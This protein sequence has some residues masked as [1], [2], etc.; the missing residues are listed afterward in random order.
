MMNMQ[1]LFIEVFCVEVVYIVDVKYFFKVLFMFKCEIQ[2]EKIFSYKN[3][4]GVKSY[5]FKMLNIYG[6]IQICYWSFLFVL[7]LVLVF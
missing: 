2:M 4:Y 7:E 5:V 3:V 6:D 1:I